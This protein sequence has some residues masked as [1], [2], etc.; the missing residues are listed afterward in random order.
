MN[1]FTLLIDRKKVGYFKSPMGARMYIEN[2]IISNFKSTKEYPDLIQT[3]LT[4]LYRGFENMDE[5][6]SFYVRIVAPDD[7]EFEVICEKHVKNV[8][9]L[10]PFDEDT[11]VDEVSCFAYR[12]FDELYPN[13]CRYT[14]YDHL[15][16]L[17]KKEVDKRQEKTYEI[18]KMLESGDDYDYVQA[19][20]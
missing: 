12:I 16:A 5:D 15:C 13:S 3:Y 4:N 6:G 8:D 14:F 7:L 18:G 2:Y 17:L 20:I 1:K 19:D 10:E 11:V 9:M